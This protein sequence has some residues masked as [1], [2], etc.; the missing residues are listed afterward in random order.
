[1]ERINICGSTK[2]RAELIVDYKKGTSEI[3][4][5][6]DDTLINR[7]KAAFSDWVLYMAVLFGILHFSFSQ[8]PILSEYAFK[9]ASWVVGTCFIIILLL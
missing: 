4:G 8:I 5:V 7:I 9:W 3:K 2:D 1:M 6:P